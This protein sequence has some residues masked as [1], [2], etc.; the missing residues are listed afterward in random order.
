MKE[1]K[2]AKI[3]YAI[4]ILAFVI[5]L[6]SLVT[7]V[8]D[9]WDLYKTTDGNI[10]SGGIDLYEM[11]IDVVFAVLELTIG[12]SLIKQW[13]TSEK[14]EV[15]KSISQLISAVVYA[16]FVKVLVSTIFS[17]VLG[18]DDESSSVKI[19]YVIVYAVYGLLVGATPTLVKK[20]KL[21]QLYWVMLLSSVIAVGFGLYEVM[22]LLDGEI[23]ELAT[24]VANTI[25]MCLIT[26]FSFSVIVY[27][28]KNP[29]DLERDVKEN[30][31]SEVIKT[32][33][34]YEI[35]K[36]YETRGTD[37]NVN[38]VISVLTALCAI[39]GIVGVVLYARENNFAQFL[40]GELNE[41]INV[42]IN[43]LTQSMADMMGL[44][45]LIIVVFTY[46]LIYLSILV[47]V[48]TKKAESKISILSS[49]SIGTLIALFSGI[50]TIF[51][52][53]L[54]FTT[55]HTLNL[56]KYSIFQIVIIVLYVVYELTKKVFRNVTKDINDGITKRGDSYN[57]HSKAIAR[58]VTFSGL[59]SILCLVV[60]FAMNFTEGVIKISYVAFALST[61][62]SIVSTKL[63][64]KHPFSEYSIVKRRIHGIDNIKEEVI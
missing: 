4:G 57:S 52:V 29:L 15:H 18:V 20:R 7:A 22:G 28:L 46:S 32:T 39:F 19:A 8:L 16:S 26:V 60:L 56:E 45:M 14:I 44:F 50:L 38:T 34:K 49:A 9:L 12:I 54:D 59:Y 36:I 5:A 31:D 17:Y 55:T 10:L 2:R 23:I 48:F 21:M 47:G 41:I 3:L 62:L 51:D 40:N 11:G 35:V 64:V 24:T 43:V 6:V 37:D 25:L 61:A 30:E 27:Y 53:F 1:T 42:I 63:E 58:V 33:E 13:K